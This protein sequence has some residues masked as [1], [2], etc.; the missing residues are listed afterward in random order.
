VLATLL[1]NPSSGDAAMTAAHLEGILAEAGYQ[2]RYQSTDD[3]WKRA[4]R[5]P[6]DLLVAAGGDGTVAKALR[7]TAGSSI[8]VAILPLGTAN[9]IAKT[10]GVVGEA[11]EIAAGWQEA[12]SRP[13]DLGVATAPWGGGTFAEGAGGGA[14]AE[15][16]IR[17]S[18][19]VEEG[20]L[21]GNETD[22]GLHL[23]RT[24]L[25]TRGPADWQVEIDGRDRSG[26]YVAVEI[27]NVRFAGPNIPL[28][29]DADPSDGVFDVCLAGAADRDRL[30]SYLHDRVEHGSARL[31]GLTTFRARSVRLV[32]PRGEAFH[33]DDEPWPQASDAGTGTIQIAVRPGAASILAEPDGDA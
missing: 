25:E 3:E 22:R 27:L 8:P 30:L 4:L 21:V 23:L 9:N 20:S 14:I 18:A 7:E 2:V 15:L 24:I 12:S 16:I 32:V 1:H 33:L 31:R 26:A 11:L 5:S 13:F 29:P 6:G 28:A 10:L 19:E 17:G